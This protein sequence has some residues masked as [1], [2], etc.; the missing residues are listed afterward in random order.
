MMGE[1]LGAGPVP[2][3]AGWAGLSA[4]ALVGA[5]DGIGVEGR[6]GHNGISHGVVVKR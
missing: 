5:V 4:C 2:P 6:L 1:A 3:F